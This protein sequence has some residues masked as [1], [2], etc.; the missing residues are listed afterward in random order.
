MNA[1]HVIVSEVL[2]FPR[3]NV[4][5]ETHLSGAGSGNLK[6]TSR[7]QKRRNRE[8]RQLCERNM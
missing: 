5:P 7:N 2:S 4:T 3:R 8:R 6:A 1:D